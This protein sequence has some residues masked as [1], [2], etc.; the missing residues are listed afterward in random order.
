M[1]LV[2]ELD[3]P[4]FDYTAPDFSADLY[5]QQ[6]AETR[7]RGWL[8]R[9]PLAYVVLDHDSGEFFLRSKVTA[10]PGRQIAEFFG[11][12]GGP[13]ADHIAKVAPPEASVTN[14]HHL[15]AAV[16]REA[17]TPPD[18]SAPD[19]FAQLEASFE[20]SPIDAS[21]QCDVLIVDEGQEQVVDDRLETFR[22]H[23]L[24][25]HE[26]IMAH[27]VE[28]HRQDGG[29][30]L[31]QVELTAFLRAP[32]DVMGPQRPVAE[33]PGPHVRRAEARAGKQ[34]GEGRGDHGGKR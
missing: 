24:E 12:T 5:H 11:V 30:N 25:G 13:L 18:F 21:R 3:L 16:A 20:R 23:W 26:Q 32:E 6:L 10:F 4:T 15:C 28:R 1:N 31:V 8:A 33:Q 29:G 19:V 14:Y 17:G 9:S 34:A 7:R 22:W 27:Q 2:S